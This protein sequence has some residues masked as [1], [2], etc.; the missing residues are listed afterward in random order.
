MELTGKGYFL[1]RILQCEK[2]DPEKIANQASD[3]GLSHMII[4]IADGAFPYNYD[5]EKKIDY[6]PAV[7]DALRARNISVWGWHY[8]Y[9]NY[10]KQEAEIAIKRTKQFA[11]DGYVINAEGEYKIP[12]RS[13]N[14]KIFMSNL[15]NSLGSTPIALSSFRYPNTHREFPWHA[16]VERCDLVM[17][18]VYWMKSHNNA[19]AQLTRSIEEFKSIFPKVTILPTGPTFK[20]WGWIPYKEEVLEFLQTAKKMNL[21]GV[22]F[23]SFDQSRQPFLQD[24]WKVVKDFQWENGN[25]NRSMADQLV[26]AL[27]TR[28][29]ELISPLYTEDAI[30]VRPELII[31]GKYA[32]NQWTQKL[33][34]EI[35]PIGK[36]IME[37]PSAKDDTISFNWNLRNANTSILLYGKDTIRV[38]NN[39]IS[40]HYTYSSPEPIEW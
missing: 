15:R 23:Y 22:N 34:N 10:P 32:I 19:G 13:A 29:I 17:P 26:D 16:F 38:K 40:N 11:L 28:N 2:G 5:K 8:V 3:A 39:R 36:F 12:G 14:A 31:K 33:L 21:P 7:V 9:G 30:H 18:Q 1:W 25:L 24:L 6:V 20:E 35:A 27:N 37:S 4:K